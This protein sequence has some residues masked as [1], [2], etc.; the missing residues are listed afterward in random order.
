MYNNKSNEPKRV[1][2]C[3][4]DDWRD[5]KFKYECTLLEDASYY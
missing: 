5:G 4:W 3:N 2:E 1:L